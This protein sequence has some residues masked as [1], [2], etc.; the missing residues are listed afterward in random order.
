MK[1][2]DTDLLAMLNDDD[3]KIIIAEIKLDDM[4]VPFKKDSKRYARYI[5][6]LG[7]LDSRSKMAK[8]NLPG[9]VYELYNKG[10][11]NMRKMLS[12]QAQVLRCIIGEILTE[13]EGEKLTPESFSDMD[14]AKCVAVLSE[15]ENKEKNNRIDI[16]LFFLQLKLN[17]VDISE[18]EKEEIKKLW[19]EKKEKRSC[20]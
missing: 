2:I 12:N 18:Q 13:C 5:S 6:R 19:N 8:T 15:I 20:S 9:I 17:A 7:R 10:D 16:D 14:S 11:L 1:K 4:L 3:I